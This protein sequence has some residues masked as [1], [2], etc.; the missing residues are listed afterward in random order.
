MSPEKL[1][2]AQSVEALFVRALGP[3]LT[4]EGRQRLK[5]VGLD[6]SERLRPAYSLEQWRGFLRVAVQDIFPSLP[7]KEAWLALGARYLQGFRQTPVG[8]ASLS[9]VT[10]LGPMRTLE[11]VPYNVRAGN[12][13]N[14]VRVEESGEGAAT[15][16]MKDVAADNP[17]F[18]AGFLAESLRVAGAGHVEVEPIAFDGTAATYRIVWNRTAA[19]PVGEAA[20][21]PGA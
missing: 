15:L 17:Y 6:L 10:R 21:A 1:I 19:A 9:L 20:P 16:W 8:R 5:G 13:F 14:E 18:S 4:R 3:Y 12:N 11:R 2:F 7:A